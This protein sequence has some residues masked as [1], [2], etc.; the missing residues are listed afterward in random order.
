LKNPDS[1]REFFLVCGC[2][3]TSL[4]KLPFELAK[5][6]I[7]T[8]FHLQGCYPPN[9]A[10]QICF[11]DLWMCKRKLEQIPFRACQNPNPNTLHLHSCSPQ[12]KNV[13]PRLQKQNC[14][15][16]VFC[17]VHALC[18]HSKCTAHSF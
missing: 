18:V 2:A 10:Q 7:Q 5:T 14:T 1:V 11:L 15:N 8:H 3:N 17:T 16:C 12:T 4:N 6:S 9:K 13:P